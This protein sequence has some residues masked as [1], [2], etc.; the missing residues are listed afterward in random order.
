M[1]R[2]EIL[3]KIAKAQAELDK[4]KGLLDEYYKSNIKDW[5]PEK[6]RVYWYV[7]DDNCVNATLNFGCE[8]HKSRI[9]TYNCFQTK[10]QAEQ[11]AEKILV[12]RI[13]EDIAKRLNKGE[14]IDWNNEEQAKY[15]ISLDITG[16]E[17]GW[18][19]EVRF[20]SQGTIYCLDMNFYKVA[21]EEIGTERLIKYL[22][23]EK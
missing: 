10:E 16:N 22:R 5:R 3:D 13:L 1:G 8:P 15:S 7:G 9:K 6:D 4:A 21:I 19:K 2:Q 14:K 12:R 11:E 17:I 20:T 23:G 18:D